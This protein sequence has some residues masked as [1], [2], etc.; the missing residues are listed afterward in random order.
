MPAI[1]ALIA[2]LLAVILTLLPGASSALSLSTAARLY[3]AGTTTHTIHHELAHMLIDRFQLPVAGRE[4]DAA[5]QYAWLRMV[6]RWRDT[7]DQ[8]PLRAAIELWHLE[9]LR[10][11]DEDDRVPAWSEHSSDRQRLF[12]GI[13]IV[14]G[15][16]PETFGGLARKYGMPEERLEA[17]E[18]EAGIIE[19]SWQELLAFAAEAGG[20]EKITLL[21]DPWAGEAPR[22]M[23]ADRLW[24]LAPSFLRRGVIPAKEIVANLNREVGFET[25]VILRFTNCGEADAYYDPEVPEVVICYEEID[26]YWRLRAYRQASDQ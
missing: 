25:A 17:C 11:A 7:G 12:L 14:A 22:S 26:A 13:C 23:T 5:D 4:E 2:P 1:R 19:A 6:D 21:I 3:I 16:Q 18:D 20:D 10:A 24:D 15:L 8:R 9:H